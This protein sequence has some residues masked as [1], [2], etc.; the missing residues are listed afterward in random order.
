MAMKELFDITQDDGMTF[1]GIPRC[2]DPANVDAEIAIVGVPMVPPYSLQ[3]ME[4]THHPEVD[5]ADTGADPGD[6]PRAIRE[7]SQSFITYN[8]NYDFDLK[9][10]LRLDSGLKI[11]DCGDVR[12]YAEDEKTFSQRS[13]EVINS[14]ANQG[15]IPIVLGGDHATTIPSLRGFANHSPICLIQVDAHMDFCDEEAGFREGNASPIRRCAELDWVV[16]IAQIGLR[17]W[18]A[19]RQQ[20]VRDAESMGSVIVTAEEIHD[21]GMERVLKKIPSVGNYYITI[22]IDGLDPSIAPGVLYPSHGGLTYYQVTK[23]LRGI[24]KKGKV[25][26]MDLVEVA[27]KLDIG[28][29]TSILATRL[30]LNLIGFLIQ[31]GYVGQQCPND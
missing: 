7:A 16:S 3:E 11:V 17:G 20:D 6:A 15:V 12:K 2:H 1:L 13:T 22:D 27:P 30:I 23:L 31:Y 26:G 28:Q 4:I 19:A 25:V 5:I 29:R 9:G 21:A 10:N 8:G 24:C 18:G 14:L